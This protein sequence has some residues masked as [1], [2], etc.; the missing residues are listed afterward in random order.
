MV[1]RFKAGNNVYDLQFCASGEK[2]SLATMD[3]QVYLVD[4][5]V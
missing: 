4:I 2:L 1:R 5:R 3:S